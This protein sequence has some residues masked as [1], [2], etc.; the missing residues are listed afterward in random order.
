MDE[1][2]YRDA[3]ASKKV[4]VRA[5]ERT[6]PAT[7]PIFA[8]WLCDA[9]G[10]YTASFFTGGA[11]L[12]MCAIMHMAAPCILSCQARRQKRKRGPTVPVPDTQP[13]VVQGEIIIMEKGWSPEN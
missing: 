11:M 5:E 7:I 9:T 10:N 1:A 6:L 4:I 8:G 13:Q 12:M 2:S 3:D